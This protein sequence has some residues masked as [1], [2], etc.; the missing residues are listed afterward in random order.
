MKGRRLLGKIN[1]IPKINVYLSN[2]ISFTSFFLASMLKRKSTCFKK[3]SPKF[4]STFIIL[5]AY[6]NLIGITTACVATKIVNTALK[7]GDKTI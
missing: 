2:F 5:L 6:T 1:P 4:N 7:L 3:F